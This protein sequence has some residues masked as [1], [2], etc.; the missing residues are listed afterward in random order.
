PAELVDRF[1]GTLGALT[2]VAADR[3]PDR[4]RFRDLVVRATDVVAV[5]LQ[6][7]QLVRHLRRVEDVAA[8]RVLGDQPPRLPLPAAADQD[9]PERYRERQRTAERLRQLVVLAAESSV[10]PAHICRKICSVSS[11]RSN[12]SA[13]G[14]NGTPRPR[15]SRS[16]Q[17]APIP[18]KARPPEST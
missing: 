9:R 10:P 17:A 4:D 3:D 16:F 18:R 15:C 14:G 2:A 1:G 8:V 11:R 13:N 12:R 7:V 5:R 6:D